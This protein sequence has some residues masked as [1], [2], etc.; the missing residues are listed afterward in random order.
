MYPGA[1]VK[2]IPIVI[3][4]DGLVTRYNQI[5]MEQLGISKKIQAYIQ[6]QT[7]K[8]TCESILIDPVQKIR[9]IQDGGRRGNAANV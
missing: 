9:S 5:Y 7:I 1:E 6:A 4:W 2:V 8:R 3:T